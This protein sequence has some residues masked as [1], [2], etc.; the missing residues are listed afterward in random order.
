MTLAPWIALC[1][2]GLVGAACIMV[3]QN[4]AVPTGGTNVIT[5]DGRGAGRVFDGIG[6][7]SAG[8]SSRLLIDY[9]EPYRSQILDYLFKPDYGASLHHLKVEIGGDVNSTDGSEPSIARTRDEMV[10]PNFN[11]GYEW[12]LMEEAKKRNPNIILDSLAWGAPG[13]IGNGHFYSQDM[14]DYVVKFIQGGKSQDNLN[15]SYMGIWNESKD[16]TSYVKL[17][18]RTLLGSGLST[19]LVCCDLYPSEE[20]WSIIGDMAKDPELKRSV[21]VVSVHYPRVNGKLTTP[22]AAKDSGKPLWSSEDQP[23]TPDNLPNTRDWTTGGRVLAELY[24]TNYIEG[25]FTK[26][27]TWSPIT[28]YYDILAAPH[29]GLMYANTPWSGHYD[30]QSAVWVTAHTTQFAQLGWRYIDSACGYL[31]GKGSYVTLRSFSSNDYSVILETIEATA[32]QDVSFRLTGGLSSKVVHVWETNAKINFEHVRDITPQ[33]G[34]WSI[35]LDPNSLY[36]FTTTTGQS[37]GNAM[38]PPAAPFPFPYSESFETTALGQSPRYSADQNGAFEVQPCAGHQGRCL[39]QVITQEP[40]PWGPMPD[41]YTMLGS[42]E[43]RDYT[44]S[45]DMLL[46]QPGEL[47]LLGRIDDADVFKDQKARWPSGYILLVDQQGAWELDSAKYKAP[48][49]KLASGKVPFAVRR[50]HRLALHFSGSSIEPSIDGT[51]VT[52]LTDTSHS[53]GMVGIGSGW[54][55]AQF[56]NFA[57]R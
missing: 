38:P 28:S 43:W 7:V 3:A 19:G 56:D 35:S 26:T 12:W 52:H 34:S 54:N 57:V 53:H 10:H 48:T 1:G 37:K 31:G 23:L 42:E 32:A 11:R 4:T 17:L 20:Q 22:Q 33:N 6:A 55:A 25:R 30:V 14:A 21:D 18:K 49:V 51:V 41:P 13:W 8:A 36:T 5:I 47:T 50:W 15:I 44:V 39:N 40:I 29:S 2:V 16:D 27:E 24:N 46:E 45:A 9:P